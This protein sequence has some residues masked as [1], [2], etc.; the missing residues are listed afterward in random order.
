MGHQPRLSQGSEARPPPTCCSVHFS[1]WA[2]SHASIPSSFRLGS[3]PHFPNYALGSSQQ[4]CWLPS[5][6]PLPRSEWFVTSPNLDLLP[7]SQISEG[8][9]VSWS[10]PN[11]LQLPTARNPMLSC[12]SRGASSKGS[13]LPS[14]SRQKS[15]KAAALNLQRTQGSGPT[16]LHPFSLAI[17]PDLFGL[18]LFIRKKR[19]PL[20]HGFAVSAREHEHLSAWHTERAQ[21]LWGR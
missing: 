10:R 11:Q 15:S 5:P 18:Q 8:D 13:Q 20:P 14:N 2:G 1:C 9:P 7:S 3:R 16:R 12:R 6:A 17:Q 21:Y 4:R 19:K